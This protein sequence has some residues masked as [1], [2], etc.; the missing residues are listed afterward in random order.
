[1]QKDNQALPVYSRPAAGARMIGIGES[2]IWAKAKND[3]TFPRP[4]KLG[5]RTT[6]F[7]T[8]ELLAWAESR[9]T[10]KGGSL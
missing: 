1:M 10:S 8:S 9:T 6:V 2:S 5:P 7:K 3:P 4:I